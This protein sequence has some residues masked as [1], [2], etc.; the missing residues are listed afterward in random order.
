[1]SW[2]SRYSAQKYQRQERRKAT[3]MIVIG[4]AFTASGVFIWFTDSAWLAL[5]SVV[6][7]LAVILGGMLTWSQSDGSIGSFRVLISACVMFAILCAI[8]VV[9]ATVAPQDF[10]GMLR[11]LYALI[12]GYLGLALFGGGLIFLLIRSLRNARSRAATPPST[13]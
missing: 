7:G 12:A 2:N 5:T 10:D 8:T 1:M 6:F 13:E 3:M 9:H 11:P 4:V